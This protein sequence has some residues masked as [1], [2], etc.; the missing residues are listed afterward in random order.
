METAGHGPLVHEQERLVHRLRRRE[1]GRVGVN[2]ACLN[3]VFS[4]YL[5]DRTAGVGKLTMVGA[6]AGPQEPGG[7]AKHGG[8]PQFLDGLHRVETLQQFRRSE[9][10]AVFYKS[11]QRGETFRPRQ[12]RKTDIHHHHTGE[13]PHG[14]EQA[15]EDPQ[16][17]VAEIEPAFA[18]HQFLTRHT[19]TPPCAS[20]AARAPP[21][22][23]QYNPATTSATSPDPIRS[24]SPSL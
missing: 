13:K 11:R 14:H 3:G 21:S 5:A 10:Y 23:R 9:P 17:A 24:P 15:H 19:V 16:P 8:K 2:P 4:A 22:G 18:T 7:A 6:I 12:L 1:T 20:S